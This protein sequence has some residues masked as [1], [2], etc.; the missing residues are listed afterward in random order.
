MNLRFGGIL[1]P[2]TLGVMHWAC[3]GVLRS[4]SWSVE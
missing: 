2:S 3:S 1:D 4:S